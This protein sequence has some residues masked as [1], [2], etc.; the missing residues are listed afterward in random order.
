[1]CT[2]CFPRILKRPELSGKLLFAEYPWLPL[3][4]SC[5][6]AHTGAEG[7]VKR[8]LLVRFSGRHLS[9][10]RWRSATLPR[11]EGKGAVN[12]NLPSF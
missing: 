9:R 10:P 12:N 8:W 2:Q 1:M 4:G 6:S 3:W 5:P 11:G 7:G